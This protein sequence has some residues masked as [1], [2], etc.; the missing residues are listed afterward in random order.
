MKANLRSKRLIPNALLGLVVALSAPGIG[1][2]AQA[3]EAPA[4]VVVLE[5]PGGQKLKAIPD[6]AGK[7]VFNNLPAGTG[8]LSVV[9]AP[10]KEAAAGEA[11]AAPATG[12]PIKAREAGSGMA[13]GKRQHKPMMFQVALDNSPESAKTQ[14]LDDWSVKPVSVVIGAASKSKELTG[15]VT[16]IK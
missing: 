12:G 7:F 11:V 5:F 4:C 2:A 14:A 6:A 15:H 1:L 3:A 10:L 8:T 9:A 16:L 13:T